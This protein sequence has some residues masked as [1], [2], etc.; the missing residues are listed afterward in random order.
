[1]STLD[2]LFAI[3]DVARRDAVV[4]EMTA[5]APIAWAHRACEGRPE[6]GTLRPSDW[7]GGVRRVARSTDGDPTDGGYTGPT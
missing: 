5:L 4:V 6:R 7:R 2:V 1:M 3:P